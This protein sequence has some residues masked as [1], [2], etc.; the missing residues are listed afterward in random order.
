MPV[1]AARRPGAGPYAHELALPIPRNAREAGAEEVLH[2]HRAIALD[3]RRLVPQMRGGLSVHVGIESGSV[4]DCMAAE[5]MVTG[6]PAVFPLAVGYVNNPHFRA[7]GYRF[8]R[9][10]FGDVRSIGQAGELRRF[11]TPRHGWS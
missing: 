6:E 5:R 7:G 2:K 8:H 3:G 9:N 4:I 1:P 11:R 10:P